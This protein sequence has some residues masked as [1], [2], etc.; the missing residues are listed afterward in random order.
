MGAKKSSE[1]G[2][3]L[4][5]DSLMDALTNVVAVLILALLL[6]NLDVTQKLVKFT[7]GLQPVTQEQLEQTRQE[8]EQLEQEAERFQQMSEATPP[9]KAALE[10]ERRNLA[11]LEK[12]AAEEKAKNEEKLRAVAALREREAELLA[13]RD[14]AKEQALAL[15]EEIKQLEALLDA[16]PLLEPIPPT[17]VTIPDSRPVPGNAREYFAMVRGDRVH[18]IDPFS[19]PEIAKKEVASRR[20]ELGGERIRRGSD[21]ILVYDQKA[22]QEMLSSLDFKPPEGQSIKVITIPHSRHPILEFVPDLIN[23]GTLAADLSK[24]RNA[25]TE[26]LKKISTDPRGVLIFLV[27]PDGFPTYL[28]AREISDKNRIP[29]GWEIDGAPT[30][31]FPLKEI[32]VKPTATPPPPAQSPP[33]GPPTLER[34]LD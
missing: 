29:A 5:L 27:A 23:G 17:V 1:Q 25:F 32:E 28:A 24:P 6:V 3:A 26:G 4:N 34:K 8:L 2:A 16:T 21:N 19:P 10:E 11:L 22:T 14:A 13:E 12:L 30:R 31:R 9:G 15:Q 33:T 20:K 18:L 7:E